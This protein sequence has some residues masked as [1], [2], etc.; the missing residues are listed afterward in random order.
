[1]DFKSGAN[2]NTYK[3][4]I[5]FASDFGMNYVLFDAGWSD[6]RDIFKLNPEMDMEVLAKYAHEKGVGLVLWTSSYAL[7]RQMENALNRFQQWGIKGIMVDF[8]NR[9]DQVT[10]NFFRRTAEETAKRH[11]FVDFHGSYKPDGINRRYP[12]VITSEGAMGLEYYK[13]S[14]KN[15]PENEVVLLF[16][17][18]V[19]GPYDYEPGAMRN[20]IP[21]NYRP[22]GNKLTSLGTRIH[23]MALCVAYESPYSKLGGNV[24][25]YLTE[26][27]YTSFL[28]KIPT[29]WEETK[30]LKAKVA[31]YA[32]IARKDENGDWYISAVNDWTARDLEIDFSFLPDEKSHKIEIYHDGINADRYASD[33]KHI[34]S[35]V[36]KTDNLRIHLAPGGGWV[37]KI[38]K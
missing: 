20:E 10:V 11:I 17:R 29:I 23:Q 13:F 12:N 2:T 16:T 26:P 32:V 4:Y 5:D 8:M 25:D 14:D 9:D 15:S 19:A 38:S 31:D 1:V 37:A 36:L 22:I 28:V 6:P 35:N 21:E 18:L 24:S 34:V 3:Y 33:Y 7:D 30:V 27:E